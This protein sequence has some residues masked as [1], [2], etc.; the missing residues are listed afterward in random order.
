M[1]L[2]DKSLRLRQLFVVTVALFFLSSC[3]DPN[4]EL[5][6]RNPNRKS[7]VTYIEIPIES[8]VLSTD[9]VI[10]DNF[11][12]ANNASPN[13]FLVGQYQDNAMGKVKAQSFLQYYPSSTT[14]VDATAVYDSV[15]AYFSLNFYGYGFTGKQTQKFSIHELTDTLTTTHRYFNGSFMPYNPVALGEAVVK[16]DYDSL[17]KQASLSTGRDTLLAIG[18]L[19]QAFG[20]RLFE[21][22]Q[23]DPNSLLTNGVKGYK[24]AFKG[25]ALVPTAGEGIIGI[26]NVGPFSRLIV[27]YHTVDGSGNITKLGRSFSYDY[28]SFTNFSADRSMTELAP[29]SQSYQSIVPSSGSRY[30]QS[31]ASVMTKLDLRK[32]Y[33]FADADSNK[34]VIINSVELI[35]DDVESPNNAPAHLAFQ[36]GIMKNNDQ[37]VNYKVSSDR[38]AMV[39]YAG[40]YTISPNEFRYYVAADLAAQNAVIEYNSN[41]KRYSGIMTL[42]VQ[43]LFR[44]KNIEG[45]VNENRIRYI[46]ACPAFP[47]MGTSV[48][49][50]IFDASKIKFRIYYTKPSLSSSLN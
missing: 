19:D 2:W 5:G 10:T 16:V 9:S 39:P 4:S 49:R 50:T 6:F 33:E 26:T 30:V 41:T 3:E 13:T 18:R 25:L 46:A 14:L 21:L 32:F 28:L 27:Y 35:I 8:S 44:N 42:F 12:D 40:H 37:F 34:N 45:V 43:S 23:S 7:K 47:A 17:K 15:V 11:L 38:D 48:T 29:L 36:F 31:G 1:N 20:N 24:Y 22:I